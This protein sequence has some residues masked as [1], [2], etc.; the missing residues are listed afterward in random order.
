MNFL[1]NYGTKVKTKYV[2]T[3]QNGKIVVFL[4]PLLNHVA[5]F[6][7]KKRNRKLKRGCFDG[8]RI[9]NQASTH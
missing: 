2:K 4:R 5:F 6:A 1:I 7:S 8:L 3:S 9:K